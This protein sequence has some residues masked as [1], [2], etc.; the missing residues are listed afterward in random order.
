MGLNNLHEHGL[1]DSGVLCV[2]WDIPNAM[3]IILRS[4]GNLG[5][6]SRLFQYMWMI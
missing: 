6:T 1:I 4:T 3:G 5:G 2:V